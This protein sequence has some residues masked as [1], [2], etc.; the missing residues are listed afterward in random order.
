M[1]IQLLMTTMSKV[2]IQF[3]CQRNLILRLRYND[4]FSVIKDIN[5][6]KSHSA[7]VILLEDQYFLGNFVLENKFMHNHWTWQLFLRSVMTVAGGM[8][9]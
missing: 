3:F 7:S 1:E 4:G 6:A 8:Y 9:W 2:W 5:Q